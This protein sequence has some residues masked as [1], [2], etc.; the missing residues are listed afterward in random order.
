MQ[1]KKRNALLNKYK[2][3]IEDLYVRNNVVIYENRLH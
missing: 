1:F 3:M 2:A